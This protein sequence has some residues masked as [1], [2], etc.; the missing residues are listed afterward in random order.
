MEDSRGI[1]GLSMSERSSMPHRDGLTM[2]DEDDADGWMSEL[3]AG[4]RT[5]ISKGVLPADKE[6]WIVSISG[7]HQPLTREADSWLRSRGL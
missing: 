5:R 1:E 6:K 4:D 7:N 2:P 3:T